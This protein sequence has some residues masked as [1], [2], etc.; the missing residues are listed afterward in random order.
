MLVRLMLFLRW[1]APCSMEELQIFLGMAGF[2]RK[3]VNDYAKI[4]VPM[5][6]QLKG[7]VRLMLLRDGQHL[8][9][10]KNFISSWGWQVS[11]ASM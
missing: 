4:S 5:T 7:A 8:V 10:W 11:I 2:Y 3:Y 1:P 9:V 6:D